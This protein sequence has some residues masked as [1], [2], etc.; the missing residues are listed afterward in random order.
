MAK[1]SL[2]LVPT[3]SKP[4]TNGTQPPRKLGKHGTDLWRRITHEYDISDAGGIELLTLICQ[5]L[6]R[7]ESLHAAIE[8]TG[9]M[10]QTRN[11][12]WRENPM[13]KG[14]LANRAFVAKMLM[15]LG[16][17]VSVTPPRGPGRPPMGGL[18]WPGDA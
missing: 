5:A 12:G 9:E 8:E 3:G 14:E 7:A 4:A 18:G 11:G 6:D 1:R 13:L 17:N 15:R 2:H 10:I 16:I